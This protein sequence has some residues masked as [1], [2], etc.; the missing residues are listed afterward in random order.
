MKKS[1]LLLA[2]LLAALLCPAAGAQIRGLLNEEEGT[3]AY[4][5]PS[6]SVTIEAEAECVTFTAGPY[7]KYAHKYFGIDAG[8]E[9]AVTYAL[10]SVKLTPYAEAD[11]SASY[12]VKLGRKSTPYFLKFT[13]QG[14]VSSADAAVSRGGEW[15]YDF[16][17]TDRSIGEGLESNLTDA[18]STLYKTVQTENGF[19]K[20]PVQQKQ[21]VEKS[22]EQKAADAAQMIFSLRKSRN[23]IIT[24]NT[25]A[26]F[27]GEAMKAAIDEIGRLEE[28]YLS[29]F[30][31]KKSSSL[32]KRTFEVVPA[33]DNAR[34]IYIAFRI[35]DSEGLQPADVVG[36]RPIVLNLRGEAASSPVVPNDG[37]G[38]SKNAVSIYYRVP[39]VMDARLLD[40]QTVL[41]Q[42]RI[43]VYQLGSVASFPL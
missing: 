18:T 43:P 25:D 15:K 6:T 10:S 8:T 14:L 3:V 26:T 41:L 17:E 19:E 2:A 24:G 5:L 23:D 16:K 39:A 28:A 4:S 38:S 30:I 1:K 31:G 9:D 20:I 42:S 33:V 11:R 21:L 7:A 40:G 12:T 34:Q 22:V 35:S 36:G 37:G 29:L 32:Q 13:S 27:S